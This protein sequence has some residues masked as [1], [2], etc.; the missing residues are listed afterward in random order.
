MDGFDERPEGSHQKVV[1]LVGRNKKVLELGCGKGYVSERLKQNGCR[2]TGIEISGD[3]AK[4]ARRH[5]EKVIVGNVETMKM[6]FRQNTFD[7]ILSGDVL[8]HLHEPKAALEKVMPFLK[9]DGV[10]IVSLPNIANWKIRLKLLLGKFDYADWGIMDRTHLRFFTRKTARKLLEDAGY[11][12]MYE[13]YVPSFPFPVFK[14]LLSRS[15][16]NAFAYQFI[17]AARKS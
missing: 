9:D 8:E 2:V 13:D 7:A 6:P 5:C 15:N 3:N 16:P 11:T 1:C 10:I 4:Q 14:K 17:F 12:I